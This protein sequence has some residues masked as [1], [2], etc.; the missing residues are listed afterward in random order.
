LLRAR[1][2]TGRREVFQQNVK[3]PEQIQT[4]GERPTTKE[5]TQTHA[6]KQTQTQNRKTTPQ[7]KNK[8]DANTQTTE[9]RHQTKGDVV[10]TER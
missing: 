6:R 10:S 9:E 5:Q 8:R 7:R 2:A 3:E 4:T 1:G